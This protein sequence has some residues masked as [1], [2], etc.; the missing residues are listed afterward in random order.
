ML[1]VYEKMIMKKHMIMKNEWM[2][3]QMNIEVFLALPRR[4]GNSP[5]DEAETKSPTLQPSTQT[6]YLVWQTMLN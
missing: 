3:E 5:S 6:S 2:I 4:R 1:Q